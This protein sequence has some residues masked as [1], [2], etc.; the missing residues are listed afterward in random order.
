MSQTAINRAV[1][2]KFLA[3]ARAD[4]VVPILAYLPSTFELKAASSVPRIGATL[5]AEVAG[6]AGIIHTDLT[7]ALRD[8]DPARLAS[9][10]GYGVHY[11][12]EAN[13]TVAEHLAGV[14]RTATGWT[15]LTGT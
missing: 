10:L 4:G 14:V 7:P 13:R 12:P 9:R 2:R 3:M 6:E 11:S 1:L 8:V 15:C 5:I